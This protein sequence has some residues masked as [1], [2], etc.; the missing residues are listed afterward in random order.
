MALGHVQQAVN[1]VFVSR[2]AESEQKIVRQCEFWDA[3]DGK[4]VLHPLVSAKIDPWVFKF[5]VGACPCSRSFRVAV[6]WC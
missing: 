2:C 4:Y 6:M 1:V 3:A 5:S